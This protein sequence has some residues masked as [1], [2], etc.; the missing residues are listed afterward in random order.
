MQRIPVAI[1]VIHARAVAS[2]CSARDR[3]RVREHNTATA[4]SIT[5]THIG[6][7]SPDGADGLRPKRCSPE[8]DAFFEL[9]ISIPSLPSAFSYVYMPTQ[10]SIL[11]HYTI[12]SY[13]YRFVNRFECNFYKSERFFF[14]SRRQEIKNNVF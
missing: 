5:E 3:G 6:N 12:I 14:F 10:S 9:T 2:P 11:N 13:L 4:Q 8:S 1:Q 7:E